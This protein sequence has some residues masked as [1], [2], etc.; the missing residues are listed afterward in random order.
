MKKILDW[1]SERRKA[2]I[3]IVMCLLYFVN[4]RYGYD[5]PLT[6]DDLAVIFGIFG[7]IAVHETVNS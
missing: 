1:I 5:F 4:K 2:F 3:P 6:T 7:S